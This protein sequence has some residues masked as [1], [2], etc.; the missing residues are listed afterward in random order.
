[1]ALPIESFLG[2]IASISI[3]FIEHLIDGDGNEATA[4]ERAALSQRTQNVVFI[5]ADV[6]K[7]KRVRITLATILTTHQI[8][9]LLNIVMS[10][11]PRLAVVGRASQLVKKVILDFPT[12]NLI[13]EQHMVANRLALVPFVDK[14]VQ[15]KLY[16]RKNEYLLDSPAQ[17]VVR[18]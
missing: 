12:V 6:A 10:Q 7:P 5:D 1:M 14:T 16:V 2:K 3:R 8:P 4:I 15:T 13:R 17:L 9:K 18:E 11:S